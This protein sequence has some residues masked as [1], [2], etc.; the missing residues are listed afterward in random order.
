MRNFSPWTPRNASLFLRN[1]RYWRDFFLGSNSRIQNGGVC[2]NSLCHRRLI[3]SAPRAFDVTVET[4]FENGYW[5]NLVDIFTFVTVGPN[6]L[7]YAPAPLVKEKG[8]KVAM[9][10]VLWREPRLRNF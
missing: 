10:V 1:W 4:P 7:A 5:Y 8:M 3:T 2:C 6:R 9:V